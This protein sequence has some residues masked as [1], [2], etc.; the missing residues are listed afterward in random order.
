MIKETVARNG[1]LRAEFFRNIWL[2][3]QVRK[4]FDTEEQMLVKKVLQEG[5]ERHQFA[6]DDVCLMS[7]IIHYTTKGLEVPYIYNRIG[8]NIKEQDTKQ[9]VLRIIRNALGFMKTEITD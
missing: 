9:I 2:V 8:R 1:N 5:V 6:I 4:R 3:E 7:E